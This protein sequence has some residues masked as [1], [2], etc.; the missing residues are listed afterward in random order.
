MIYNFSLSLK[1]KESKQNCKFYQH[2]Q[3][4]LPETFQLYLLRAFRIIKQFSHSRNYYSLKKTHTI[5]LFPLKKLLFLSE[6]W[7]SS[8]VAQTP[9]VVEE[10]SARVEGA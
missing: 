3:I 6:S 5:S 10:N 2:I 4:Q 7:K 1:K 9:G 8:G